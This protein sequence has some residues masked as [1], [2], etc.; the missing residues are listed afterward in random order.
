MSA[1]RHHFCDIDGTLTYNGGEGWGT[2]NWEMIG[3]IRELAKEESVV[4]WSA[5]GR[6]Y[7]QLF[8]DKYSIGAEF[9]IGKPNMIIDDTATIR[10]P[11]LMFTFTPAQ[12]LEYMKARRSIHDIPNEVFE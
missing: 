6:K 12:F 3:A 11:N 10:P 5:R 2:P 9:C 8:N 4:L 7:A 1:D